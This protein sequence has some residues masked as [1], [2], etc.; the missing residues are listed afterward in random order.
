MIWKSLHSADAAHVHHAGLE[1]S[2]LRKDITTCWE[3][4]DIGVGSR[5]R[6]FLGSQKGSQYPQSSRN[7]ILTLLGTVQ[8]TGSRNKFWGWPALC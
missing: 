7:I 6:N 3:A 4:G 1:D 2:L 5:G 8:V